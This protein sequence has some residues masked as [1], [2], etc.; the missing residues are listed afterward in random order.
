M[1]LLLRTVLRKSTGDIAMRDAVV[2]GAPVRI[3]RG[4]DCE[5]H[6]GDPRVLLG[7]AMLEER[8]GGVFIEALGEGALDVNGA[9]ARVAALTEGDVVRVG[10]YELRVIAPPDV[11]HDFAL[12]CELV[13]PLAGGADSLAA[14]STLSLAATGIGPRRWAWALAILILAAF[15]AWPLTG[16]FLAGKGGG[17]ALDLFAGARGLWQAGPLTGPHRLVGGNCNA[18][19]QRPFVPVESAA[20]LTCHEKTDEHADVARFAFTSLAGQRCQSCHKEHEGE[21]RLTVKAEAF[22]TGCHAGLKERTQGASSLAD[23]RGFDRHPPFRFEKTEVS[24]GGFA[25][26]HKAHLAANGISDPDG[27]RKR[28]GCADCHAAQGGGTVM[29]MPRFETAC[30][31]CHALRFEPKAPDR[32]M[33][34]GS[35]AAAKQ[36]VR[37]TYARIALEGGFPAAPED[38]PAVVRRRP[39]APFATKEAR[40]EALQWAEARA[41]AV[42]AG[43]FG[44]G[45]CGECHALVETPDDP[46]AWR[47]APVRPAPARLRAA[48]FDHRPHRDVG[49]TTCHKAPASDS[50]GDMLLPGVETCRNCH[51]GPDAARRIPTACVDCHEF[52]GRHGGLA[53][54]QAASELDAQL[55]AHAGD[56]VVGAA[57]PHHRVGAEDQPAGNRALVAH[58]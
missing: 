2:I 58:P 29:A 49:C 52:H 27:G 31:G 13:S 33:P 36:F 14:R 47:V 44:K 9:P 20:C 54:R 40:L 28:L 34:H 53:H 22:C 5:T 57:Q 39:G 48:R 26:S 7:H 56:V 51:G 37:D 21:A 23:V 10:P 18:C 35:V 25:F 8:A 16:H 6:L 42:I 24:A 4:A 3:G 43:R 11:A 38:A 45:L 1:R 17:A 19:H 15:V 30:A 50:A 41:R 55:R 46:L 12:S 32:A